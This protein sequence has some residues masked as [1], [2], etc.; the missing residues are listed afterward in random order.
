M[1]LG[2][3]LLFNNGLLMLLLHWGYGIFWFSPIFT[4]FHPLFTRFLP[5]S[6]EFAEDFVKLMRRIYVI[7]AAN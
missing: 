2:A 7:E 5:F 4:Y 3:L 6:L 1:I